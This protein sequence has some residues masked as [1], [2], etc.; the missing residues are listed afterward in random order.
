MQGFAYCG[1]DDDAPTRP[2]DATRLS[3]SLLAAV[4]RRSR[5]DD[6]TISATWAVPEGLQRATPSTG[7][8]HPTKRM[9]LTAPVPVCSREATT[10]PSVA[11]AT[12]RG[13]KIVL[14]LL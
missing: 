5:Q 3:R 7:P 2:S 14:A 11:R 6:V 1:P 12:G 8:R 13:Y 4:T 9:T 10:A